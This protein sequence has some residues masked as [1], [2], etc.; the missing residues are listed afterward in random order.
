MVIRSLRYIKIVVIILV[1]VPL[2]SGVFSTP[3]LDEDC[4]TLPC[5]TERQLQRQIS[6]S[7]EES[8]SRFLR[9]S[10]FYDQPLYPTEQELRSFPVNRGIFA[11]F[12][13][14][15]DLIGNALGNFNDIIPFEDYLFLF[16]R[17]LMRDIKLVSVKDFGNL[18]I[19]LNRLA[20]GDYFMRL[21]ID[22]SRFYNRDN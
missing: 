3:N 11:S 10:V 6:Y 7:F 13:D 15:D 16:D 4:I 19:N 8:L 20:Q 14:D 22:F 1:L 9:S 2:S 5:L 12:L 21:Q 17:Y 18:R